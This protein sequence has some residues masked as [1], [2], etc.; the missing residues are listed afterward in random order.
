MSGLTNDSIRTALDAVLPEGTSVYAA[1]FTTAPN[2]EGTGYVEIESAWYSRVAVSSWV[3]Q[4]IGNVGWRKVNK[5]N[6]TFAPSAEG[7]SL[8]IAAV[9]IFDASTGGTL[10]AWA[11]TRA[12]AANGQLSDEVSYILPDGD[13]AQIPAEQLK[14]G[15]RQDEDLV[16]SLIVT[17]EQAVTTVDATPTTID[18]QALEDSYAYH[19]EA[20]VW[21]R[22]SS[23]GTD[24]HY[25]RKIVASYYRDTTGQ[26]W[27]V[28]EKH[29]DGA[30]TRVGFT[31][32]TADLVLSGNIVL[33]QVIG[34]PKQIVWGSEMKVRREAA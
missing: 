26:L 23:G 17:T 13:T 6:V 32:A 18:S 14:I 21:G 3:Q 24:E 31:T 12:L 9:G 16:L 33:L 2:D 29:T 19:I 25:R 20:W 5:S 22:Y 27:N 11:P 30:E 15:I 8:G 1:L 28:D 4:Q 10:L 7:A 34:E